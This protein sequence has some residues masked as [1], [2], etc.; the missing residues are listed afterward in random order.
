MRIVI[1]PGHGGK[2]PGAIGPG[3]TMEKDITLAVSGILEEILS[4]MG[5]E[6]LLTRT[7]DVYLLPD[8]RAYFANQRKG[9]CFVSIHCNAA[10]NRNADGFEVWTSRGKTASDSLATQIIAAWGLAFPW[11]RIRSDWS[12]DD[13]DLEAGFAVLTKTK[14]PAVLIELQFISNPTWETWLGEHGNQL[15]MAQAIAAGV[16]AWR[17]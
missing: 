3:R 17:A 15:E 13:A 4:R 10:A 1:D 16:E 5:H 2:D 7:A 9:D 6:V 12:D 8:I 11:M 14:M